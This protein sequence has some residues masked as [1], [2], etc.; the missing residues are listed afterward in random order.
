MRDELT[1]VREDYPG[2]PVAFLGRLGVVDRGI[3]ARGHLCGGGAEDV[4]Q[5]WGEEVSGNYFELL[6]VN[7]IKGRTFLPEEDQTPGT[8]PVAVISHGLWQRRFGSDMNVTE[9][10]LT[11]NGESYTV[12]GALPAGSP[13][14]E[15]VPSKKDRSLVASELVLATV[16]GIA[17]G[18]RNTG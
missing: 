15:P 16:S 12:V 2:E 17:Q 6:G 11:L 1:R 10:P 5:I 8:H 13:A 3:P 4:E 18:L 9:K 14:A 7:A